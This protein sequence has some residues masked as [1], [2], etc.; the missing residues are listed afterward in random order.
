MAAAG[1]GLALFRIAYG[2][3]MLNEARRKTADG[4][5]TSGTR[6]AEAVQPHLASAE[7]LYRPFLTDVV[8]PNAATCSLLVVIGE[9][10]V[11]LSLILGLL[12]RLG[13]ALGVVLLA[14]YLLMKGVASALNGDDTWLFLVGFLGLGLGAAGL[15][16]GLDG[17]LARVAPVARPLTGGARRPDTASVD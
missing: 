7:A 5:L 13:S 9:W 16:W 3:Y 2:L 17:P 12:T 4:W 10:A 14:N 15:V 6:L 11:A 1:Y 8:L